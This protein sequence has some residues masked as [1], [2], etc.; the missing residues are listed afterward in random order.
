[1][2]RRL[3]LAL[4]VAAV[5]TGALIGAPSMIV[6]G[7]QVGG[8]TKQA[9]AQPGAPDYCAPW[10]RSWYVS[11]GGWYYYWWWRWCHNPSI[12]GGWYVDWGGWDWW[13]PAPPGSSPGFKYSGG[14]PS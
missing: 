10:E 1:M 8:D 6:G 2:V 3:I 7:L 4:T 11:S 9:I 5:M 14:P 13:S 12:E